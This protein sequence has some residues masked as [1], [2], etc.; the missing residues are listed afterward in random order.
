MTTTCEAVNWELSWSSPTSESFSVHLT[1]VIS[2]RNTSFI[3]EFSHLVI[4]HFQ[5]MH[6][7][8]L[9]NFWQ[10]YSWKPPLNLQIACTCGMLYYYQP[11]FE[12]S[13][14]NQVSPLFKKLRKTNLKIKNFIVTLMYTLKMIFPKY[15]Q[16]CETEIQP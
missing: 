4:Y 3:N 10:N 6:K 8:L 5:S 13:G 15:I 12:G 1:V 16:V 11:T 2:S 7:Q 9:P 14:E